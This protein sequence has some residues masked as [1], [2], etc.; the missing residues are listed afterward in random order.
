MMCGDDALAVRYP[1][2]T[3]KTTAELMAEYEDS[4]GHNSNF[5]LELSPDPDGVIPQ[6][7]LSAYLLCVL[8]LCIVAKRP[9]NY[10][11]DCYFTYV[12]F[13]AHFHGY[14]KANY[15]AE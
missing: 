7:D 3:S 12:S 14:Y 10:S 11:F 4:V 5:M 2:E 6:A 13:S 8:S 9:Q 1:N 15:S